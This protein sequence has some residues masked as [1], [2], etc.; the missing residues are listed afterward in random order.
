MLERRRV[1]YYF[2]PMFLEEF[3]EQGGIPDI[4]E[5]RTSLDLSLASTKACVEFI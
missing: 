1:K 3:L 2:G 4:T 5:D